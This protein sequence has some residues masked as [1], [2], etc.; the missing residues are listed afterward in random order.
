MLHRLRRVPG[1][2]LEKPGLGLRLGNPV[3]RLEANQAVCR[4]VGRGRVVE[5]RVLPQLFQGRGRPQAVARSV[6]HR[7][8]PRPP[9]GLLPPVLFRQLPQLVPLLPNFT[10]RVRPGTAVLGL[11]VDELS[12]EV[13]E[14]VDELLHPPALRR[15]EATALHFL[16]HRGVKVGDDVG[17]VGGLKLGQDLRGACGEKLGE[18]AGG[19]RAH[20]GVVR[21]ALEPA[22][23]LL[24]ELRRLRPQKRGAPPC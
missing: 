9:V 6:L 3:G 18:S 23:H 10:P 8:L 14:R 15:H 16:P 21:G 1:E 20:V 22:L 19:C 17:K 7:V 11:E 13:L 5:L 12:E 4:Q 24:R 2:V